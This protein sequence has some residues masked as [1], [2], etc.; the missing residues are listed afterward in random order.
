MDLTPEPQFP[1]PQ[2]G[3][4]CS[5]HALGVSGQLSVVMGKGAQTAPRFTSEIGYYLL[6]SLVEVSAFT[7][8]QIVIFSALEKGRGSGFPGK[9]RA[10][11]SVSSELGSE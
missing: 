3:D 1:P 5:T 9:G 11:M 10:C 2:I 6:F 8:F 4:A 7:R